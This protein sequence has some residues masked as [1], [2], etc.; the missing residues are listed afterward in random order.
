MTKS[1]R[2]PGRNTLTSELRRRKSQRSG[3]RQPVRWRS[4]VTKRRVKTCIR[5]YEKHESFSDVEEFY[6]KKF[7][8]QYAVSAL[9]V[10]LMVPLAGAQSQPAGLQ[11]AFG[12][13]KSHRTSPT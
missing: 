6:M 9:A 3:K 5:R 2:L 4:G 13:D 1:H 11:A 7:L 12:K 8:I 10:A